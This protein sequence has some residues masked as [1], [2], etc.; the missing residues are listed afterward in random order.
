[1]NLIWYFETQVP[2]GRFTAVVGENAHG[3]SAEI[4]GKI[5][6]P[7]RS[8]DFDKP[9]PY[10]QD[11]HYGPA[12]VHARSVTKLF[13]TVMRKIENDI[14]HVIRSFTVRD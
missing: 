7:A 11:Q 1:M 9:T 10:M 3:Y 12:E 4:E 6:P 8:E 14:G 2:Y 5:V 13:R